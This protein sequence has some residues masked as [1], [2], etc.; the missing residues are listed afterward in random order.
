MRRD[1]KDVFEGLREK[2]KIGIPSARWSRATLPLLS[3]STLP[4]FSHSPAHHPESCDSRLAASRS[5]LALRRRWTVVRGTSSRLELVPVPVPAAPDAPRGSAPV[6]RPDADAAAADA[7]V[8]E[9]YD[10]RCGARFSGSDSARASLAIVVV[11][12]RECACA[13]ACARPGSCSCALSRS[14]SFP[15]PFRGLASREVLS[16]SSLS[17]RSQSI[18]LSLSSVVPVAPSRPRS[19]STWVRACSAAIAQGHY[20][21]RGRLHRFAPTGSGPVRCLR[22][23]RRQRSGTRGL[24][25]FKGAH[26]M[27]GCGRSARVGFRDARPR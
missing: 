25:I 1:G 8:K 19:E 7:D 17:P 10:A 5:A 12:S 21:C 4:Y 18:F 26:W 24:R 27:A 2:R 3:S 13:C 14:R 11:G 23:R 22:R 15:V 9:L 16:L 6:E 20:L